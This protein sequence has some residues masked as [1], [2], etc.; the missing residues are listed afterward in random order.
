MI[1]NHH[2]IF[3]GQRTVDRQINYREK[4]SFVKS[5]QQILMVE[6]V[7]KVGK[8]GCSLVGLWERVEDI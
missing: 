4:R 7:M 6:R 3:Y 8:V 2:R 5:I 1:L